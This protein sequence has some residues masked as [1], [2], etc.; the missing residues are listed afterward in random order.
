MSALILYAV[1]AA[2]V[3][4]LLSLAAWSAVSAGADVVRLAWRGMR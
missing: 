3:T 1:A 2:D 4:V